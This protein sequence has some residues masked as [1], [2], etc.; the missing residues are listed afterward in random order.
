MNASRDMLRKDLFTFENDLEGHNN[1][2]IQHIKSELAYFFNAC[3]I[4]NGSHDEKNC[5]EDI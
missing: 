5:P 4:C 3:I 1:K 2:E